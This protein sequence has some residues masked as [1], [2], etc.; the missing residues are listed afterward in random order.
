MRWNAPVPQI[1]AYGLSEPVNSLWLRVLRKIVSD[2][3]HVSIIGEAGARLPNEHGKTLTPNIF[4]IAGH[5]DFAPQAS[6]EVDRYRSYFTLVGCLRAP[7]YDV[8][9]PKLQT[10]LFP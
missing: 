4:G 2:S 5:H 10:R 6:D 8:R 7:R 3:R 9:R 1:V